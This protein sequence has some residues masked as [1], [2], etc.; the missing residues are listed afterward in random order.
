METHI[1]SIV[2]GRLNKTSLPNAK[3]LLAIGNSQN[4][5]RIFFADKVV[6]VEGISDRIFF[7]SVFQKLGVTTGTLRSCEIIRVGGKVILIP[8]FL[9]CV[10]ATY[11]MR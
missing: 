10:L 4:N 8:M 7:E 1:Y 5:E 11:L 6:L 3:D 9:S 2:R